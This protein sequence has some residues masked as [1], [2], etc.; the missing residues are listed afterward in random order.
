M[1]L[2]TLSSRLLASQSDCQV[3]MS[4]LS[5]SSLVRLF[6]VPVDLYSQQFLEFTEPSPTD[7]STFI[8]KQLRRVLSF[9]RSSIY[10]AR[11]VVWSPLQR[12]W[13]L[14]PLEDN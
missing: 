10:G 2:H 11:N 9:G 1:L 3:V 7:G 8:T 12:R 4:Q 5:T 6:P 14:L 13:H